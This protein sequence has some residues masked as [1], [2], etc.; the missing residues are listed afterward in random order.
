MSV[1]IAFRIDWHLQPCATPQRPP[2]LFGL[3]VGGFP[4]QKHAAAASEPLWQVPQKENGL[5]K[6]AKFNAHTMELI[7]RKTDFRGN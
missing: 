6:N 1:A 2:S 5:L 4:R 3:A 7:I